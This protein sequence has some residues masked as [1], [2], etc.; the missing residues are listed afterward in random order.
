MRLIVAFAIAMSVTAASAQ[1]F[2]G[3]VPRVQDGDTF[4]R[5]DATACHRI[6]ICG[7][8]APERG[9]PGYREPTA[10]LRLIVGS[11]PVRCVQVGSG[12]VSDERS[13]PTNRTRYVAQCF[14][15]ADD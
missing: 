3:T 10:A 13:R 11:Q 5:F 4:D 8:D 15:G 2:T 6:R 9:E 14:V 7:I 1:Q 12:T